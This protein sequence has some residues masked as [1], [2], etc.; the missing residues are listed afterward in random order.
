MNPEE[1]ITLVEYNLWANHRVLVKAARLSPDKL[2]ADAYLSYRSVMATL[3]HIL[4]A[5]W[6][7][8]EGAQFGNLPSK[9]LSPSDFINLASLQQRWKA[10]DSLLREFVLG[11]SQDKLQGLVT[12]KWPQARPRSRPLWHILMHIVNHGTHHRSEVGQYLNILKH[13]PGDLDFI[14]FVAKTNR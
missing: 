5:Q 10:E 9:A 4:D 13:S 2:V 6:Y 14:K 1:A 3:T 12:Y 7:W 11:L 8:R